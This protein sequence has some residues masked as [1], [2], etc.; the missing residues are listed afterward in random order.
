MSGPAAYRRLPGKGRTPVSWHTLWLGDDHLLAVHA[1][2]YH[3]TY[4][5]YYFKDIQAIVTRR[6]ARGRNWSFGMALLVLFVTAAALTC[7]PGGARTAWV[8]VDVPIV[9]AL[10]VNLLLGPTCICH[11]QMPLSRHELPSVTRLRTARRVMERVRPAIDRV[12]GVMTGAEVSAHVAA[13]GAGIPGNGPRRPSPAPSPPIT[14]GEGYGGL[15]HRAVFGLLLADAVFTPFEIAY[16]TKAL[17]GLNIMLT[18]VQFGLIIAALVKQ[19][20]HVVP[21]AAKR[22]TW[23]ALANMLI[24][25]VVAWSYATVFA[26]KT[27]MASRG[28]AYRGGAL[29]EL[30]PMDHPFMLVMAGISVVVEV[31]VGVAGLAAMLREAAPAGAPAP[32]RT[33]AVP[34]NEVP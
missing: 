5:R 19:S 15:P 27:A 4:R 34:G 24:G 10:T 25:L 31:V 12:Q 9:L 26:F 23:V 7:D 16:H 18:L 32:Q 14:A 3:E 8:V 30:N 20:D 22:L 11:L 1:T 21:Q 6:T 2:G 13:A 33:G 29:P 17:Q 28:T